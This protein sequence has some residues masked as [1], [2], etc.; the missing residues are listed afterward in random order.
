MYHFIT[1]SFLH[2]VR[3]YNNT[4]KLG[5]KRSTFDVSI[6]LWSLFS[7]AK[8]KAIENLKTVFHV[9]AGHST[10]MTFQFAF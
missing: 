8:P 4:E 1:D 5:L 2:A 9:G 10:T 3:I 6:K 7:K